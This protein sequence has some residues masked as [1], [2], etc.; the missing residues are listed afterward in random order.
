MKRIVPFLV[1]WILLLAVPAFG[2]G[3][4]DPVDV[5]QPTMKTLDQIEPRILIESLPY[6]IE[7]AGSYV[8][9]GNA[10]LG[11]TN[12]HGITVAANDVVL[13]LGGFA[14]EGPTDGYGEPL[15]ES[16]SAI[17]QED[18]YR[19]LTV[20]NGSILKWN[21][22][23]SEGVGMVQLLG[24]GNKIQNVT[25]RFC[26]RGI[27]MGPGALVQDCR[28]L[29]M[30]EEG[31]TFGIWVGEGSVVKD[32]AVLTVQGG[33]AVGIGS[34]RACVFERC[35]VISNRSFSGVSSYAFLVGSHGVVENCVVK[36]WGGGLTEYGFLLSDFTRAARCTAMACQYGISLG[37]R[38]EAIDSSASGC[39]VAGFYVHEGGALIER[40]AAQDN[41]IGISVGHNNVVRGCIAMDNLNQGIEVRDE[42]NVIE[43]NACNH[44]ASSGIYVAT[45]ANR[46][47][48]N[49]L[50]RNDYGLYFR[51]WDPTSHAK[52]NWA[53]KNTARGNT[54]QNYFVGVSNSVAPIEPAGTFSNPWANFEL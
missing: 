41:Q 26:S 22:Q 33:S 46:I 4:I 25:V 19:T 14:M 10:M 38:T 11:S 18:G 30:A 32:C 45:D 53:A 15:S 50:V 1:P 23:A 7:K 2:Q 6:V 8:L 36:G 48:G 29:N 24:T 27:K 34:D 54:T 12:E 39:A 9:D 37:E 52:W 28:V 16:G 35:T 17:Y 49:H 42:N 13:D 44:N 31:E 40:C 47:E 51:Y 3:P 43:G 21:D 5:P 20:K